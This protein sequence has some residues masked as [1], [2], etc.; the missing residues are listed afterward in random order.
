MEL[1]NRALR[2]ALMLGTGLGLWAVMSPAFGQGAEMLETVTV[3]GYRAS[4]ENALSTKRTSAEMVDAINAEDVGKMPDANLAESL[5][6][7]PGIS[8]AR[9]NGEGRTITVRG[10]GADFTRVTINGMEAL[11]T[12]GGTLSGDNP[13]RSRQFDF[14]TF[15]SELFSNLKVKKTAAASTD[16]GSLG[17]TVDLSTGHPFDYGEKFVASV[18]NATYETGHPFNPR[19]A[20][21]ASETFFGGKLGALV[22]VAYNMRNQKINYYTNG[23]GG[24]TYYGNN[25]LMNV[26]GTPSGTITRDGFASPTGTSCSG[27]DGVVPG[28]SVTNG[29]YCGALSG[30][31]PATYALINN[32]RG[33]NAATDSSGAWK[34]PGPN[35]ELGDPSLVDQ[36]LYQSRIGITTA[37]QWQVD[38]DTLLSFDGLFSSFYQKSTSNLVTWLGWGRNNTNATLNTANAKT[39]LSSVFATCKESTAAVHAPQTCSYAKSML[40][41]NY[42]TTPGSAGYRAS[43]PN[44]MLYLI[45]TV[46]RPTTKLLAGQVDNGVVDYLK[47]DNVDDRTTADQSRATTQF[48]QGTLKLEHNFSSKLHMDAFYG[49]AVSRNHQ[50]GL[51]ASMERFDVG[52]ATGEGSY[53]YDIRGNGFTPQEVSYGFDVADPT[54]W[55]F[56]KGYS[57]LRRYMYLTSNKYTN[58]ATNW[59]YQAADEL[60]LRFGFTS[61]IF[62]FNTTRYVRATDTTINPSLQEMGVT[63]SDVMRVVKFTA[64]DL[65]MGGNTPTS[66]AV[67]DLDKFEQYTNYR[68]N[69]VN[70]YGD[71][72]ISNLNSQNSG[73]NGTTTFNVQE[74][75]KSYYLQGDFQNIIVFGNELRGNIG[76]RY[77]TTDVQSYG[78][79]VA[80]FKA[81]ATNSYDDVLP[82]LNLVYGLNDDMVIR[83]GLSK[84]M[85][86]PVLAN[87]A[88][89]IS[90]VSP[91]ATAGA[92]GTISAGNPYLKPFRANTIDVS[93]E[94]YFDRGAVLSVAAFAKY[95]KN[96]PQSQT[97]SGPLNTLISPDMVTAIAAN[98]AKDTPQYANIMDP[99]TTWALTSYQNA[100]GGVL[101]GVEVNYQQQ[102]NFL[103]HPFDGFGINAN[104]TYVQSKVHYLFRDGVSTVLK[105]HLMPWFGASPNSFNATIYYTADKWEA[106]LS[107]SYR[108]RYLDAYPIKAGAYPVGYGT[109]LAINEAIYGKSSFYLDSSFSYNIS[110]N[111]AAKIDALNLTNEHTGKYW[112]YQNQ[113]QRA[114]YDAMTGRQIFVGV[115]YKY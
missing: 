97:V 90:G 21:L 75:D 55:D 17:A 93:Y 1:Q 68:C 29:A 16:E 37:E 25:T 106:R 82:S 59:S 34:N 51:M 6:R 12:A 9:D 24:Y 2:G 101:R 36:E 96:N 104:Y 114:T 56:V 35:Y 89:T 78:Y 22:S 66:F 74:H 4:L 48:M 40:P 58:I 110:D 49:M 53:V 14:N 107:S 18:N 60:T 64:A 47:A 84:V 69:C 63:S 50:E 7:L 10:L 43:D 88:P 77:A 54:K 42:F 87:M 113:T 19:I 83:A 28:V 26:A 52:S 67:P 15:A 71:W 80:G 57:A 103:P 100:P 45:S 85:S 79:T 32:P 20:G 91:G 38:E 98:Y 33:H 27:N 81:S 95:V 109:S 108:S 111:L 3:T 8:I 102:F 86:R 99:T 65:G 61:K 44:G 76:V 70:D 13:N 112:M 39:D 94:W 46:G 30:S 5:Q 31:D 72:R 73:S 115:T 92:S 11:A 62:N 105:D 23:A 41:A